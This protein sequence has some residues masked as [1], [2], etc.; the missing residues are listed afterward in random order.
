MSCSRSGAG[1]REK[2]VKILC[3]YPSHIR[4]SVD[5]EVFI[6]SFFF[7]GSGGHNEAIYWGGGACSGRWESS[8]LEGAPSKLQN[9]HLSS[10]I[11]LRRP[12]FVGSKNVQEAPHNCQKIN[13]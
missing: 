4:R 5:P 9:G 2:N 3:R 7:L 12:K 11:P 10:S 13:K 6:F 1:E 8:E